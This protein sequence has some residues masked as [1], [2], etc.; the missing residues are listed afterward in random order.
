MTPNDR[1]TAAD[2]IV[3][4]LAGVMLTFLALSIL[5]HGAKP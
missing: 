3:G 4:V 5:I 2:W 1:R